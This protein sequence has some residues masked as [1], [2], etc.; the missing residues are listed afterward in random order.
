MTAKATI[1]LLD[2]YKTILELRLIKADGGSAVDTLTNMMNSFELLI[3]KNSC[4]SM[5]AECYTFVVMQLGLQRKAE[6]F[7]YK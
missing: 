6:E 5:L 7:I 3:G 1:D 4:L 2:T